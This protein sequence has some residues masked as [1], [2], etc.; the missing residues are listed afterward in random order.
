MRPHHIGNGV[1][2]KYGAISHP[3]DYVF[4]EARHQISLRPYGSTES[5]S[6][7]PVS[8]CWNLTCLLRRRRNSRD[9]CSPTSPRS[10]QRNIL[11]F[12]VSAFRRLSCSRN[13]QE[14]VQTN[15][16]NRSMRRRIPAA[17]LNRP[18]MYVAYYVG[19]GL[20]L[21]HVPI[22]CRSTGLSIESSDCSL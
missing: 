19:R 15:F 18:R 8:T 11:K 6:R 17:D 12:E 16:K 20:P 13:I 3:D 21:P 10:G 5:R 22:F 7:P 14:F 9:Q 4:R 1:L 2:F